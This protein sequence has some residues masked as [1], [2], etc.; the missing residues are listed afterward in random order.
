MDARHTSSQHTHH[1]VISSNYTHERKAQHSVG[2]IIL[3]VRI[4]IRRVCF[5]HQHYTAEAREDSDHLDLKE[6][7]VVDEKAKQ[8]GPESLRVLDY[9]NRAEWQQRYRKHI[10]PLAEK[11]HGTAC[12]KVHSEMFRHVPYVDFV[13]LDK[14]ARH[15]EVGKDPGESKVQEVDMQC[16]GLFGH[17]VVESV[18]DAED[19]DENDGGQV[20]IFPSEVVS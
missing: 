5:R 16:L 18:E 9:L 4:N 7:F 11:L 20:P 3:F 15:Q 14:D 2:L 6:L 13:R 8:G 17:D 12:R 19:V 1:A 10:G